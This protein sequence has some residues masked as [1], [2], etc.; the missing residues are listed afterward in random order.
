MHKSKGGFTVLESLIVLVITSLVIGLGMI[1]IN[2]ATVARV[3]ERI[4]WQSLK[5]Q[6]QF[7]ERYAVENKTTVNVTFLKHQVQFQ[8]P[9]QPER[10]YEFNYPKSVAKSSERD[11]IT[12]KSNGYI[13]PKTIYWTVNNGQIIKQT[14]QLG[15]GIY[16]IKAQ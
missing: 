5:R 12:I 10:N 9:E 11:L 14:F 7:N 13:S 3:Q 8:Y 16:R 6:W 1:S 2:R 15:W 4:F